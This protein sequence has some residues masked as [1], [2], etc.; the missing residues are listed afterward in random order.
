MALG[1]GHEY[2]GSQWKWEKNIF[3]SF[4]SASTVENQSMGLLLMVGDDIFQ[5]SDETVLRFCDKR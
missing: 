2:F 4:F 5:V 1:F 3:Y